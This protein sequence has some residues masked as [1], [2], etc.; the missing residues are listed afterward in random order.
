MSSAISANPATRAITCPHAGCTA[1]SPRPTTS[2]SWWKW[3]G[4][5]I[6]TASPAAWVFVWW[7]AANLVPRANAIYHKYVDEFGAKAVGRRKRIVP[8][9]Y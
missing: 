1:T 7:T 4:F 8:F 6:L 3:T 9:I 2:A 5:A